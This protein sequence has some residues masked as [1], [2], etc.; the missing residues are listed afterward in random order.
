MGNTAFDPVDRNRDEVLGLVRRASESGRRI[1]GYFDGS[2]YFGAATPTRLPDGSNGIK[3]DWL[4]PEE[5][6]GGRVF[7]LR[8]SRG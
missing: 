1:D 2:R 6:R 3:F 4:G 8:A 7:R 5:V